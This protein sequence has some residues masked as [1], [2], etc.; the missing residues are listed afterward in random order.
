M[1]L[2]R[3]EKLSNLLIQIE[4]EM[5]SLD[6]WSRSP[7]AED[8]FQS[9]APFCADTMAFT[10][11]L[12]WVFVFRFRVLIENEHPLPEKS[13]IH[14]MAEEMFKPLSQD[15]DALLELIATFDRELSR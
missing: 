7:P 12:Q 14:P 5:K 11:W 2:A 4:N 10:D 3:Q 1:I 8:A 13:D 6:L 9:S 15:T